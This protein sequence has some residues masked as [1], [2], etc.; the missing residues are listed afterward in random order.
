MVLKATYKIT[1]GPWS[2]DSADDPRTEFIALET[3]LSVGSCNDCCRISLYAPGE[4]PGLLEGLVSEA[5]GALGLGAGSGQQAFS[6]QVR[7]NHIKPGDPIIIRLTSGEVSGKVM[8]AEVQS[9]DSSFG[10]TRITGRTAVQKMAN[11]RLNQV[12]ENQSFKQI[13]NDLAGQAGVTSGNV[14]TGSRYPYLV[15][16]ESKNLYQILQELAMGEGMDVYFDTDNRLNINQFSKTGA[17][18]TFN[19]GTDIF[20]LRVFNYQMNNQHILVYGESP[21]SNQGTDTWHWIARDLSP[22]QSEV[23]SGG[24]TLSFHSGVIRTKDA[25]D[26][27]AASKYGAIKDNSTWGRL[28]ILGNP[29]V[30]PGDAIEIKN[31]QKP[32][33]NGLF[34]VTAVRHILNKEEGYVTRLGFTGSGGAAAANSLLGGLAGNLT[35]A[36][37]L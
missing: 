32:E 26:M 10:Q 7:G 11:T 6:I 18:H 19:Y 2:I 24:Q 33:L 27:L 21:A 17:D 36:L 31:A 5:A 4:E 9:V 35:G 3:H 13:V 37:G 15:V 30:K 34:K 12:Y 29:A 25:A 8:T 20:D 23:G 14:E 28:K 22:V 1:I 16:H